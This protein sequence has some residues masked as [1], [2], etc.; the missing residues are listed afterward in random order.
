MC[1]SIAVEAAISVASCYN[2]SGTGTCASTC[3]LSPSPIKRIFAAATSIKSIWAR[4]IIMCDVSTVNAN[5]VQESIGTI[6]T[7][8]SF[9]LGVK[10]PG[11]RT[12]IITPYEIGKA[13]A[14]VSVLIS[15]SSSIEYISAVETISTS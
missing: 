10:I 3:W 11:T 4:I 12:L 8:T 6:V 9:M 5:I 15:C 14:L 2:I 1:Y 7:S 13:I